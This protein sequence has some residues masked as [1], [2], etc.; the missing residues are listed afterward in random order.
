MVRGT[1]L[2]KKYLESSKIFWSAKKYRMFRNIP[3]SI[4]TAIIVQV[5]FRLLVFLMNEAMVHGNYDEQS[6]TGKIY[7]RNPD[8]G[9]FQL[10]GAI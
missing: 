7:T 3:E 4:G 8:T 2:G 6:Y 10:Y 1:R 5:Y 9:D